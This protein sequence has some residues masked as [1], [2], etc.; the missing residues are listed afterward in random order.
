[1]TNF[2]TF[3]TP[4]EIVRESEK[5]VMVI[6]ERNNSWMVED[7]LNCRVQFW[8]PKS[9]IEIAD[10]KVVSASSWIIKSKLEE[11]NQ[12]VLDHN[13]SWKGFE[14]AAL[15]TVE[16]EQRREQALSAGIKKYEAL[17]AKAKAAGLKIRNRMKTAT[18]MRIAAEHGVTL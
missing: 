1:M 5:A 2:K 9:Q 16:D 4:L 13:Q 18:I 6:A 17:V 8:M 7:R 14:P 3:V 11:N 12:Y 15:A 10:G